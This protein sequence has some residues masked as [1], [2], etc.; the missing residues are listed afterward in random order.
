MKRGLIVAMVAAL[1]TACQTADDPTTILNGRV[2][3]AGYQPI[4]RANIE[5][6]TAAFFGLLREPAGVVQFSPEHD[7]FFSVGR[8][9]RGTYRVTASAPGYIEQVKQV[10]MAPPLPATVEF[11]LEPALARNS[12]CGRVQPGTHRG[13][14]PLDCRSVARR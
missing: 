3:D 12:D 5:V 6:D 8:L 11:V 13:E 9:A 2:T 4:P 1:L 14:P 10:D 7:G